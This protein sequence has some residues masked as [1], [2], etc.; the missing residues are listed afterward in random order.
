M[1]SLPPQELRWRRLARRGEHRKAALALQ[2]LLFADR[3]AAR[4]VL[5]GHAWSRAGRRDQAL[6][7]LKQGCWLFAR[8]GD[9]R[10]AEVVKMLLRQFQG[11]G[12]VQAA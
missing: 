9:H 5:L 3:R 11:E 2:E 4:W 12:A 6:D 7:A 10:K 8:Q 1:C